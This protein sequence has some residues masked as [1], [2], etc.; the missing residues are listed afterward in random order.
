MRKYDIR[1]LHNGDSSSGTL[2]LQLHTTS[3]TS[4]V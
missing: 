1:F 4:A 2:M 3:G